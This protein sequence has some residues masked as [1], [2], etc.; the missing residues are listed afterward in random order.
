[1]ASQELLS[2]RSPLEWNWDRV[3]G[4]FHT[5]STAEHWSTPAHGRNSTWSTH[6]RRYL[7]VTRERYGGASSP[8]IHP[9]PA[10]KGAL[11]VAGPVEH[12]DQSLALVDDVVVHERDP[13]DPVLD[14]QLRLE[15]VHERVRVEM[16]VPYPDLQPHVERRPT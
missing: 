7:Q 12:T 1:M 10:L 6:H 11:E 14:V 16:P 13:D 8:F 5:P 9:D 15:V 4:L 3:L 2:G